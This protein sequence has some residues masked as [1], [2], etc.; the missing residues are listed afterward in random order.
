MTNIEWLEKVKK[1]EEEYI[2]ITEINYELQRKGITK[3]LLSNE[4]RQAKALEIIAEELMGINN[5]LMTI[6]VNGIKQQITHP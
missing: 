5:G 3:R 2:K 1:E 6:I 4:Y